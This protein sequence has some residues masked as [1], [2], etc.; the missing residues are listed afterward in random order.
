MKKIKI[1]YVL[2][3]LSYGGVEQ[4]IYSYIEKFDTKKFEFDIM[5]QGIIMPSIRKKNQKFAVTISVFSII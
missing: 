2:P 4:V 1:L 3:A 5:T